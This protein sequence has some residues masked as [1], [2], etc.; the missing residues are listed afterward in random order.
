[1]LDSLGIP[2]ELENQAIHFTKHRPR[3]IELQTWKIHWQ[4]DN[5]L[6]TGKKYK[7]YTSPNATCNGMQDT[8]KCVDAN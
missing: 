3:V 2:R 4:T 8:D 1:M 7:G 5:Q 6:Q